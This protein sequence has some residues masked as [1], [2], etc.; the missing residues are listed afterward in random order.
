M[1]TGF[2]STAAAAAADNVKG[3]IDRF[4]RRMPPPGHQASAFLSGSSEDCGIIA[5]VKMR[6]PSRG[7]LMGGSDPELLA[8]LYEK[9]GAEAVSVVVE[10]KHFGGSP[11]LFKKVRE[12]TDLPMLWK[13]FIVNPYQIQLA[14]ALG[15]SA[16]LLIVGLVSDDDLRSFIGLTRDLGLAALVE[17]HGEEELG[18]ALSAGADIVGVNNRN[19]I[20]LEVDTS[21][22][23]RVVPLFPAGLRTVAESGMRGPEEVRRMAGL[24]YRAVLVGEAL[25]TADD[26]EEL[27]EKMVKAGRRAE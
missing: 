9:A 6:S 25:V 23:E 27:L 26:P 17:I 7:D 20:S 16:V 2:L 21:I 11:E 22:S 14:A 5:E 3:W 19:L 15:A 13:D 24:G 18:R 4:G 1:K 12:R 10:E 8:G